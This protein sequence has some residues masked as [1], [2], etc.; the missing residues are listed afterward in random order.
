MSCINT[1]PRSRGKFIL[2][3]N[4]LQRAI[5]VFSKFIC[6]YLAENVHSCQKPPNL[7]SAY[8]GLSQRKANPPAAA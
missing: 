4:N 7:I 3:I 6:P 1:P 8:P 2:I 5:Q